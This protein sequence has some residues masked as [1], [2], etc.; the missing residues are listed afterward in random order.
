MLVRLDCSEECFLIHIFAATDFDPK[1]CGNRLIFI[2]VV[3]VVSIIV[4]IISCTVVAVSDI[5]STLRR[6]RTLEWKTQT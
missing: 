4:S 1:H 3:V 5:W 2:V 6:K